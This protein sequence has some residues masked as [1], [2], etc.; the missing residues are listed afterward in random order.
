MIE[1]P[2]LEKITYLFS[3]EG[4][5]NGSTEEYEELEI[6]SKKSL[7]LQKEIASRMVSKKTLRKNF[8]DDSLSIFLE[9]SFDMLNYQ[10]FTRKLKKGIK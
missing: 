2:T 8:N 3:Q 4:N 1:K 9:D 10:A 7:D 6:Q 5:G